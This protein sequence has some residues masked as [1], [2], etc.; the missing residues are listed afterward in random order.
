MKRVTG[1]LMVVLVLGLAVSSAVSSGVFVS[2][3]KA[4]DSN[5][6]YNEFWDI[7]ENESYLVYKLNATHNLSAAPALVKNS[8]RGEEN[9]AE[10]SALIWVARDELKASGIKTYYTA[11]ELREMA[12]N[13]SKNG[14]P[15]D[16][17]KSLKEQGWTDDEIKAL[18]DYIRKN[19]DNITS[20]FD[21][22]EFLKN[23][24]K[25]FVD[26][27]FKYSSYESW[28]IW[29]WKWEGLP[30]FTDT[31]PNNISI[32]PLLAQDWLDLYAAYASNNTTALVKAAG[33]MSADMYFLVTSMGSY[34]SKPVTLV[35]L[36]DKKI[37]NYRSSLDDL[38][39][40]NNLLVSDVEY[41]TFDFKNP[42][43]F[44]TYTWHIYWRNPL[45]AYNLTRQIY[46][47]AFAMENGNDNPELRWILNEKMGELKGSLITNITEEVSVTDIK[48]HPIKIEPPHQ[49]IGMQSRGGSSSSLQV[50]GTKTSVGY[51]PTSHTP[52]A[53]ELE[54]LTPDNDEGRLD[55][56][57]ISVVVDSNSSDSVSYHIEVK[58]EA[59]KNAVSD[60]EVNLT[61]ATTGESDSGNL[62]LIYEGS[63]ASWRSHEF[64]ASVG[65][66]S[67]TI[68]GS[69]SIT[70]TPNCGDSP[71]STHGKIAPATCNVP[72]TITRSYSKT[73]ELDDTSIDPSK[74]HFTIQPSKTYV[75]A[76]K[77]VDFNITITND[78]DETISG[79]YSIKIS[80]PQPN[81]DYEW[82]SY[83]DHVSVPAHKTKKLHVTTITYGSPGTSEYYGTFDFGVSSASDSGEVIIS[84]SDGG[85]DQPSGGLE[86]ESVQLNPNSNI[87]A[88]DTVSFNVIVNNSYSSS[89][90]VEL[91]LLIDGEE[92][93]STG[94]SVGAGPENSF[95]LQ[96]VAEAGE[97]SY[98][99]KVYT[100]DENRNEELEDLDGGSLKVLGS[101]NTIGSNNLSEGVTIENFGC[102]PRE[103]GLYEW[104]FDR[105]KVLCTVVVQ[106]NGPEV[107]IAPRVVVDDIEAFWLNTRVLPGNSSLVIKY[108]VKFSD[109]LA[110]LIYGPAATAISFVKT[111]EER[112]N[113]TCRR[114]VCYTPIITH[115]L[116]EDHTI[117][118][119]IYKA[120]T[121]MST[122]E[123]LAQSEDIIVTVKYDGYV[124]KKWAEYAI[125]EPT[126]TLGTMYGVS[127]FTSVI[128]AN[129]VI[130]ESGQVV[131]S[132]SIGGLM[133]IFG[134]CI[135]DDNSYGGD[136]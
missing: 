106:N 37:M 88:G 65:G 68:H 99:V 27:A 16:T 54:A 7:L 84:S 115:Y 133:S 92:V 57:S 44:T 22:L 2:A 49:P 6:V 18:E 55:V 129:M 69:V 61:D 3:S 94:G 11:D 30:D 103:V 56:D 45:R 21:M 82:A 48:N 34:S 116:P 50:T 95:A 42:G 101:G 102:A 14:L 25:A 5:S 19:A 40:F 130:T 120:I 127:Y 121:Y 66:D 132:G 23:F 24:S 13:I 53:I 83:N 64:T 85:T 134:S 128:L 73:V 81:G 29:K 72:H 12:Q 28:A 43:K 107:R 79:Y 1:I 52:T 59:E 125:V 32:N 46:S 71:T 62:G 39:F 89:K 26:V 119:R 77:S 112:G 131:L 20:G 74:V 110:Q 9:A 90:Q 135:M 109:G 111:I 126:F 75:T 10:V 93:D 91:E 96:W 15:E 8:R 80:I 63:F 78:N 36:K 67:I 31:I 136:I 114:G 47:L 123:M 70:Y 117:G 113:T 76:G 97:H 98:T 118:L 104:R 100:I 108:E 38:L 4:V 33:S 41:T 122:T 124:G 58:V 51:T 86:I 17:V 35:F 87:K 60:V 105:D